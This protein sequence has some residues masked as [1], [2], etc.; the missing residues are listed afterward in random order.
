MLVWKAFSSEGVFVGIPSLIYIQ[1]IFCP[2]LK[3]VT[4]NG[5]WSEAYIKVTEYP[6]LPNFPKV[7]K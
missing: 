4:T 7:R 3:K 6:P 2:L 5:Q 1:L